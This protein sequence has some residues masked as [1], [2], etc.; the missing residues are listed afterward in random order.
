VTGRA[1]SRRRW[2]APLL[3]ALGLLAAC[4]VTGPVDIDTN[5]DACARCRMSIDGL[6]HAGEIVTGKGEVRKYDSLGCMV[7]DYRALTASGGTLAGSW[8]IDYDT[9]KWL[10]AQQAYYARADFATDHM[11][12]GVAAAATRDRAL[13][14]A[15]GDASRVG[16]WLALQAW[17]R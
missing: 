10:Q 5:A 7:A 6:A 2:H 11:G 16:D 13:K 14:I 3:A 12:F 1:R 17:G 9:K 8:V 4:A 15:G